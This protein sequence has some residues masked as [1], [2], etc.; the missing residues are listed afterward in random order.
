[1][2]SNACWL[3]FPV[4]GRLGV[5]LKITFGR[6]LLLRPFFKATVRV[7]GGEKRGQVFSAYVDPRE[8]LEDLHAQGCRAVLDT[9]E[10]LEPV[11]LENL[12]VPAR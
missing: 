1:M 3:V 12:K 5:C 2:S 7:C 4:D 8:L 11:T 9:G 6:R 10:T